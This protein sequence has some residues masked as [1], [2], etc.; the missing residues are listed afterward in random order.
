[1]LAIA[2]ALTRSWTAFYTRGLP[3]DLRSRR[4]EEIESDLWE[5]RRQAG[6]Q[7]ETQLG[8]ALHILLRLVLGAPSDLVWRVET[9]SAVRSGKELN[10]K[11]KRWTLRR[12]G[13]LI[14]AA[15]VLPIPPSWIKSAAAAVNPSAREESTLSAVLLGIGAHACAMPI[16]LGLMTIFWEGL[17]ISVARFAEGS[18]E[19]G[20]GLAAL[21]GLYL[22]RTTP[23]FGVAL[24]AGSTVAMAFLATWA[25]PGIIVIGLALAVM[26]V[27]RWFAPSP[28]PAMAT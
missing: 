2:V 10:V 17:A 13:A 14:F 19:V 12:V 26:A 16:A 24:V 8:T 1:M 15:A 11:D 4:R 22:A 21:A 6:S 7:R 3:P 20:V 25:L 23:A 28:T 5:Q 27:V 18:A 9:G